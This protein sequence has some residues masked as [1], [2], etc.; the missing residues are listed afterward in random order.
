MA[1]STGR[2]LSGSGPVAGLPG[3]GQRTDEASEGGAGGTVFPG[4]TSV[5]HQR[6]PPR[7]HRISD[8]CNA[9]PKASCRF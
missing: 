5:Q 8:F 6:L 3:G 7:E 9:D 2:Y 1:G 4:V